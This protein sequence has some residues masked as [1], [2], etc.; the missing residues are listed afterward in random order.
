ML[1]QYYAQKYPE[2]FDPNISADLLYCGPY[3]LEDLLPD[4]TQ[5]IGE[6]ILSPT[7]SYAPV[8]NKT[9]NELGHHVRG[10]V[11]CSGGAQTKCLRFG[12]N[13]HFV[14]DNL[15]PTPPLFAAIQRASG[16]HWDE[17][18][19]VFNMGHRMEI[20]LPHDKVQELIDIARSFEIDAR[21]IGYTEYAKQNH[22]TL[23]HANGEVF[24]Y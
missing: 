15:F 23:T 7:R 13:V 19:R 22:L 20:Y 24:E 6:A 18:Y 12:R 8:I 11:H 10:L 14:K 16:T 21:Q 1:S 17:M 4:S 3:R 2:T 5:T 9:L